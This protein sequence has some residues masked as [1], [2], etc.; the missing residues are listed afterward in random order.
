VQDDEY[1]GLPDAL[2]SASGNLIEGCKL[3]RQSAEGCQG[4][5]AV[6]DGNHR[7]D[8]SEPSPVLIAVC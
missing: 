1:K 7:A 3:Y 6:M 8:I 2:Y 4:V 5:A